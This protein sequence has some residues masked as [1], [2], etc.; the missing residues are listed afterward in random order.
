VVQ[1]GIDALKAVWHR[2]AVDADG[3]TGDD[4]VK[5][6]VSDAIKTTAMRFGVALDLWRKEEASGKPSE[7]SVPAAEPRSDGRQ[8]PAQGQQNGQQRDARPLARSEPPA[9]Q[10]VPQQDEEDGNPEAFAVITAAGREHGWDPRK[11]AVRY[12][13]QFGEE[14]RQVKSVPRATA[15]VKLLEASSDE[16]KAPATNGAAQ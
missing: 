7:E 12:K 11:V 9:A 5:E 8:R 2:G 15:F 14:I 1:A 3:K 13:A 16:L 4:A 6:A 10:S